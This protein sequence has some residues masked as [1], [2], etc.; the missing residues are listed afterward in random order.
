MAGWAV[1]MNKD[2]HMN[3]KKG[4]VTKFLGMFSEKNLTYSPDEGCD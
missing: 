2:A 4:G 3:R 1:I